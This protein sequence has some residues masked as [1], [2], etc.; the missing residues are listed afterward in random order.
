MA[1]NGQVSKGTTAVAMRRMADADPELAARL[2]PPVAAGRGRDPP[3]RSQLPARARGPRR[4][5]GRAPR[6]PRRGQ[7]GR[8]RRGAERRGVRDLDRRRHPR[9]AGGGRQPDR[10]ARPRAAEAARQAP[11]GARPPRPL[12]GRRPPRPRPARPPGRSRPP[13]PLARLRDRPRVDPRPPVHGRLRAGRRGRWPLA[14]RRRR[15]RGQHRPGLGDEPDA[16][17]RIRYSDWLRMLAGEITPS[18][19]MRLGLTEIE[20]RIPPVTMLGR[21]IDRAEGIDGPELAREERQRRRQA[22]N[23]RQLGRAKVS[24]NGAGG[25]RRRPGRGKAPAR[26]PDEL[27]A[28]LRALGAPELARPRARLLASTRSTGWSARARP[29]STP[30]SASAASTSARSGSPPTSRRSCWP[31]R[32]GRSR[33]SSPPSS[34]TRCATRSSSTAGRPR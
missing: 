17:V 19:S 11:Q 25:R 8:R 31:R 26:R 10:R 23:A 30:P 7:R 20:G 22:Q 3:G 27:R 5:A 16:V 18:E 9:Q 28:A 33:P 24:A 32:A 29:S 34:S 21:W 12:P 13:L 2:D 1:R 14:R 6:R 4:L 15:R